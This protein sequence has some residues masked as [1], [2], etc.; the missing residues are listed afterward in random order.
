LSD[1]IVSRK[2]TK[3]VGTNL[4]KKRDRSINKKCVECFQKL[5]EIMFECALP[6]CLK[7]GT[8]RCSI[9]LRE[10]YCS[11]ECQ[12][13]DWKNHKKI[14]KILKRLSNHL[15]PYNQVEEVLKEIFKLPGNKRIL[16]H[17]LSYAKF[18]FGD[19]ILGQTYR[20][21]GDFGRIYNLQ[22]EINIMIPI[23]QRSINVFIDD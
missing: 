12:K 4:P 22:V 18:Q 15:Q 13:L 9:C 6:G 2:R 19:R 3:G 14:C 11:G 23:Y 5:L 10:P 8:N 1:I 7:A 17:F 16:Y 20:E 21:R